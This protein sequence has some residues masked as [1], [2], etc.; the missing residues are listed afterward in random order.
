MVNGSMLLL[1]MAFMSFSLGCQTQNAS[2]RALA[3]VATTVKKAMEGW[4]TYVKIAKASD[5]DQ[6]AVKKVYENYQAVA[7]IARTA[8]T[9]YKETGKP[10]D[11]KIIDALV[12]SQ[13]DLLTLIAV[14]SDE[15][16]KVEPV[17]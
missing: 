6:R 17:K 12:Q 9:E 4:F 11:Q 10:V 3:T 8:Y 13:V 16:V 14:L 15:N 5:E 2:G 7:R 1:L